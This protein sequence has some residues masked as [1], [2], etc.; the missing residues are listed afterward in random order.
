VE[1]IGDKLD[2]NFGN[3][4]PDPSLAG[5]F[6]KGLRCAQKKSDYFFTAVF[7]GDGDRVVFYDENDDMIDMDFVL[8]KYVEHFAK[9]NKEKKKMSVA[10]DVTV[11]RAMDDVCDKHGISLTRLKVGRAY[12]TDHMKK[13]DCVFGGER[14]GHLLFRDFNYLD[15]PDMAVIVML[16]IIAQEEPGRLFSAMFAEYKRKYVIKSASIALSANSSSEHIMSH[17]ANLYK[18]HI[19]NCV[20]GI[21]VDMG[22]YWFNVRPSNTEPMIK[23]VL[24]S[25]DQDITTDEL[26]KLV[27]QT[28]IYC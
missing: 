4:G 19:V 25:T 7:D 6:L 12:F 3:H 2:G 26:R 23:I 20:D 13:E 27:F 22:T 16:K 5:P 15:N 18:D 14:S 24:E 9:Q 28:F 1:F 11:S 17:L 10:C 21:S 8:C